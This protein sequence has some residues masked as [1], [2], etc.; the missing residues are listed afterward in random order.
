MFF[1]GLDIFGWILRTSHINEARKQKALRI[2]NSN[3]KL[4][5]LCSA[6]GF[7]NE[8]YVSRWLK[9]NFEVNFNKL[10]NKTHRP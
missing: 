2:I 10:K 3:T 7:E 5:E 4:S 6:L 8:L 9:K 1:V